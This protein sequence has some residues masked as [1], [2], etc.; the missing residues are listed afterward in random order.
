MP[1]PHERLPWELLEPV[2]GSVNDEERAAV[3]AAFSV[4]TLNPGEPWVRENDPSSALGVVTRG[5]LSVSVFTPRGPFEVKR[6]GPGDVLG[7]VALFDP[8]PASATV[9]A[10]EACEVASLEFVELEGL[11]ERYPRVA[12]TATRELCRR[13]CNRLRSVNDTSWRDKPSSARAKQGSFW[14]VF[15]RWFGGSDE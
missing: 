4:A 1:T 6:I 13:M 14:S 9:T 8:G 3:T 2:F 5:Q 12:A 15:Q 7:E 10:L 11:R